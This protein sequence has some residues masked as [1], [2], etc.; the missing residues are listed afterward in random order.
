MGVVLGD[1]G[2]DEFRDGP[3]LESVG[4]HG[5]DPAQQQRVMGE[6]EVGSQVFRLLD[7]GVHRVEGE[8]DVGD[9]SS[10]VSDSESDAVPGLGVGR[11]PK[12][13]AD[14]DDVRN[15]R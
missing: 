8:V 9:L 7:D 15:A 4:C 3:A 1:A 10:W 2:A 13:V 6:E 5:G 14:A 12:R 11:R